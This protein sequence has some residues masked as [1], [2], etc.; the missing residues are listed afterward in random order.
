MRLLVALLSLFALTLAPLGAA[1]AVPLPNHATACADHHQGSQSKHDAAMTDCIAKCCTA[2][3]A[4]TTAEPLPV[5]TSLA[6]PHP[7]YRVIHD[8]AR[9]S[10]PHPYEPPPPRIS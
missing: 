6:V 9:R 10:P 3:S 1:P 2:T 7:V 5:S 8:A 4:A